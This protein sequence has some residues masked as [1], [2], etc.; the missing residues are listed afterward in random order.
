[1]SESITSSAL[2]RLASKAASQDAKIDAKFERVIE[3]AE[4]RAEVGKVE[5]EVTPRAAI[6]SALPSLPS[7]SPEPEP[8]SHEVYDFEDPLELAQILMPTMQ[9]HPW[10]D[11]ISKELA[12][13]GATQHNPF[14]LCLVACNGSG[15]DAFVIAPFVTWF[16]LTRKN[17]LAVITSS[18]GTQLTAQTETYI[19]R[20]CNAFNAWIGREVLKVNKRFIRCLETGSEC[21]MFATD[22]AG[23]AEGYHPLEPGAEMAIIANEAKSIPDEIFEALSR[24]TGF[25]YWLEV[26][27]PGEPI[28]QMYSS[29]TD[30]AILGYRTKHVTS[31]ECPHKDPNEIERDKIRYGEH[32]ALFRSKHLALFTQVNGQFVIRLEQLN[33]C[34]DACRSHIGKKWKLR[35]GIDVAL[36]N[37]G[38]ETVV[39]ITLG[40]KRIAQLTLHSDDVTVLTRDI[41]K[42][43]RAQGVPLD[44]DLIFIDDGGVGR[45]LWPLLRDKGWVNMQR[46]LNQF[47][48]FNNVE[49]A[50][51]GAELWFNASRFIEE[52]LLLLPVDDKLFMEQ[53][54]ARKYSRSATGKIKLESKLE[55]KAEGRK[56]PD[57]VDAY[58]LSFHGLTVEDFHAALKQGDAVD[59]PVPRTSPARALSA[60]ELVG[61]NRDGKKFNAARYQPTSADDDAEEIQALLSGS[62]PEDKRTPRNFVNA[63]MGMVRFSTRN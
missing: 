37:G 51:R 14:K 18:S 30:A 23:K 20:M 10:Q 49:F 43:L 42:F 38:D 27:T 9:F 36:S 15:K 35:V 44:S 3:R 55:M 45:A 13:A 11:N 53:F 22:E 26:S 34:R 41:D 28:G 52:C 47:R 5:E 21:R 1:M 6:T 4:F 19:A 56:S 63:L 16:L 12:A 17:G 58:L 24:C 25:N 32:S 59:V 60:K 61:V 39:C 50:N 48:A 8:A 31:Y 40:N 46:I 33:K 7:E 57:R 62:S 2:A 54:A 29:Y